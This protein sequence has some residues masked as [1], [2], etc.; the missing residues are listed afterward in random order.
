M[1][2][3]PGNLSLTTYWKDPKPGVGRVVDSGLSFLGY[4]RVTCKVST[5]RSS[6]PEDQYMGVNE[7]R[8]LKP[9]CGGCSY[10]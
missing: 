3:P 8:K 5:W 2:T 7:V 6:M 1:T 4:W 9:D 10:R